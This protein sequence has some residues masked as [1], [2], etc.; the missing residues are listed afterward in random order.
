MCGHSGGVLSLGR[1]FPIVS[2]PKQKIN[3]QSSTEAEILG[4]DKFMPAIFW[5]HYFMRTQGYAVKDKVFFQDNKSSILLE[6]HGK[7]SSSKRTKH[8]NIQYLIITGR[9]NNE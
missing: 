7:A 1:G 5:T 8:I 9:V 6:K 2:S 4:A 3:T